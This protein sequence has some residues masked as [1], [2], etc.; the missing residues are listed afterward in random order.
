M[1]RV[2]AA[3]SW[4]ERAHATGVRWTG[5]LPAWALAGLVGVLLVGAWA[6]VHAAGGTR[7]AMPHVFYVPILLATLPFGLWGGVAVGLVAT[8]LCGPLMP[9]D[10][11]SGEAQAATNWL[12]RGGF[13][14]VVGTL[15]G[16][17]AQTLRGSYEQ[18]LASFFQTQLDPAS[19]DV[20]EPDPEVRNQL[21]EV[22]S[23]RRF[24]P[25]FQPIYALDDGRLVAV[26]ALTRF[27]T[28]PHRPP[29]VWFEEAARAGLGVD[30]ELAAIQAALD[31]SDQIPSQVALS[32]NSSPDTLADPRLLELVARHPDRQLVVEVTEHAVVEDYQKL[33]TALVQL[34]RRGVRLAVDD[35]GA[36]FASLRHIVSLAPEFIKLDTSLTQNVRADPIRRALAQSLVQFAYQTGSRLVVE[37]VEDEADLRAWQQ[38]GAYAAQGFLLARPGPLPVALTS[39]L[40]RRHA[41]DPDTIGRP[42]EQQL[43]R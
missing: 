39:A 24:H 4:S 31:A 38:I 35:A 18:G 26:E 33:D 16:V 43:A 34:R 12:T 10:V 2:S 7:T 19:L 1:R 9:L 25:V 13:F 11:A 27:D 17:V 28:E 23:S 37:G 14:V 42:V 30:L 5:R 6:I 29:N 40:I 20:S 41:A 36:G 22:L 21:E 15:A 32:V 8:V 3:A